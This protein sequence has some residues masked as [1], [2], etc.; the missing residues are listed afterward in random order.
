M[1]P[2]HEPKFD[3]RDEILILETLRTGWVSSGGKFVDQFERNFAEYV[4]AKFAVSTSSGT[5]AI[6]LMLETLKKLKGINSPFEVI[7]PDLSFIATA[8]AVI[9]AGGRPVF[10]DSGI[11]SLNIDGKSLERFL[12][13]NYKFSEDTGY[14][15][16]LSSL[17]L[18]CVLPAHIMGWAG[19]IENIHEVCEQSGLVLLEDA[20]EASGSR[21]LN[22]KHVGL[23]GLASVFSFNGNKILSTGG[24]GM[25]VTDDE[26]FAA[27]AKHLSTTA[28]TDDL[29]SVHD[30][31]GFNFRMVN[32]IAALGIS[33][34]SYLD[35]RLIEKRKIRDNYH[36]YLE[37]VKDVHLYSE[38]L[39]VS[40]NWLVNIVLENNRQMEKVLKNLNSNN[41]G[42]R[43]LWQ[44]FHLQPAFS[45]YEQPET[46]WPNSVNIWNRTLSLPSSPHLP[47]ETVKMISKIVIDSLV[48]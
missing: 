10:L 30:M 9:H 22:G 20:A 16:K 4:G 11:G 28:K 42:A 27:L 31:A 5:V 43:P 26:N 18:L 34:L 14:V 36:S 47:E 29:R 12:L 45:S 15:S 1:I 41:I 35:E 25:I 7:V 46:K 38:E 6:Q 13:K 19:D 39:T 23:H 3:E 32:I 48:L 2:L 44:P 21:L 8:N 37:D 40:N 24:G 33:Q 17:K